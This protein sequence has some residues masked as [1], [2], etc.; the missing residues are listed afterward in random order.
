M[1]PGKFISLIQ[2]NIFPMGKKIKS[3]LKCSQLVIKTA[4]SCLIVPMLGLFICHA[5]PIFDLDWN[6]GSNEFL[7]ASGDLTCAVW[8]VETSKLLSR[9]IGHTV[10]IRCVEACQYNPSK[11]LLVA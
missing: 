7:T 11:R 6:A 3:C 2:I 5:S 9:G 8:D 4:A 1:K 10:S